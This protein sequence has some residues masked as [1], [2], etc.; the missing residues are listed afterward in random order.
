MTSNQLII[1]AGFL[2]VFCSNFANH[3]SVLRELEKLRY[4]S[5]DTIPSRSIAGPPP[6]SPP[7]Q[8]DM[9]TDSAEQY[10]RPLFTTDSAQYGMGNLHKNPNPNGGT[11]PEYDP[12]NIFKS[13]EKSQ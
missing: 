13:R 11:V 12:D 2:F 9:Y 3:Q 4:H 1:I 10:A 6:P 7:R 8:V 5:H